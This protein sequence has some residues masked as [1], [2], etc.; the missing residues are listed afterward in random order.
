MDEERYRGRRV[1]CGSDFLEVGDDAP[2]DLA[3]FR[4]LLVVVASQTMEWAV[5]ITNDP[6][7]DNKT[8]RLL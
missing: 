6:H 5:I 7:L 2:L 8:F 4:I 3:G 1:M